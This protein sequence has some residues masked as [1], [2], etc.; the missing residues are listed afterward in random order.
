MSRSVKGA[1][2]LILL[3]ASV[4]AI[5]TAPQ[6]PAASAGP[7]PQASPS[8]SGAQQK[9]AVYESATVLKAVTRLVVV[10]VVATD[11]KGEAVTDLERVDFTV[12][13]DG[14]E[15]QIRVFHFQQPSVAVSA[16]AGPRPAVS[17]AV[18]KL[19]DN[20]FTNVPK[21]NA[22]STLNVLLL[23]ALNTTLP[24]QSYVRDEMIK[25]LAKM[26]QGRPVAVYI[27]GSKLALLQDFTSDP[28]ALKELV[29]KVKGKMS[30][31]LD[32]STGGPDQELLPPGAADSGLVPA[33]MLQ[34]MMQFEQER[35]AFQTD[36]RV[37]YTLNALNAISRSLS[38]YPGRKNLIWISEAFPLSIDPNM[39]LTGD[40][41]AGTR[42]YGQQI[43]AAADAL[44]DAQIAVYPVDARGLVPSSVFDAASTGRD[45]FGRTMNG[46]RT[47]AAISIESAQLQAVHGTMQDMAERTGG[48]A[49]YNRNDIDR[50]IDKSIEDGSTYYTLAYYPENKDWNGKFRKIQV[51]VSRS[52]IKL[53][54]R[55]GYYAVDPKAF[56]EQNKKQQATLFGEALS[57]DAPVSTG[58]KF[59]AGV[60]PPSD[61]TQNK[62][63]VNF[64]LDPEAISFEGEEDGLQR[65]MV[66][67][68]V[69]AYSAKGKLIKTEASTVNASLK[70]ETYRRVM[71]SAF[72]CQQYIELPAGNYYL[73]LGVRDDRTGLVG[74]ANGRVNVAQT[75]EGTPVAPHAE[76]KK[77]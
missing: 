9:T 4:A 24:H 48:K 74:T 55:L 21:Y 68:V 26:P 33:E 34:S 12:L 10:D 41:F 58:L 32:N 29:K 28:E 77:P 60:I 8:S 51:K 75:P 61:K 3:I 70:P 62:V 35:T 13:E 37:T 30:P 18:F 65:A 23:D 14:M 17:P 27:L 1:C 20:V 46:P 57:L 52:G 56:A 53:R 47:G 71:Q 6:Q 49:F 67:C 5:R 36:L 59:Q 44:I 11:K 43:A 45:R 15:Q 69:Q 19:P 63:L 25:Y 31:L 7:T 73:R 38:G 76:E 16:S 22:N 40:I 50:A 2:F 66:D 54:H 64:A 72:P 42:N 39:E